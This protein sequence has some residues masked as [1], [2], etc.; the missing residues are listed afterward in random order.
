MTPNENL[1]VK[2]EYSMQ[3]FSFM[4]YEV[5]LDQLAILIIRTFAETPWKLVES[6]EY[7][8]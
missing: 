2:T 3:K 8:M 6:L 7:Y 4:V 5:L 1:S